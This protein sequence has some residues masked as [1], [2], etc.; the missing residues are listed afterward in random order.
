MVTFAGRAAPLTIL[1]EE[2]AMPLINLSVKHG[3]TLEDARARLEQTVSEA[4]ERF[5]AMVQRVEW[6]ADRNSVVVY[7]A[8]FE[9]K[10]SVDPQDVHIVG[11]IP[12]LGRLL[13]GPVIA[14]LKGILEQKFQKKLT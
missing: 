6:A 14:G 10:M 9:V 2:T 11:D 1:A 4:C 8:G 7:G 3:R 5:A 13:G 12:L